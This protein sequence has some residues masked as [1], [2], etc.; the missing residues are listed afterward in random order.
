[1][2]LKL[3]LA[4]LSMTATLAL[5]TTA[6]ADAS[7][8]SGQ[9][10]PTEEAPAAT[11]REPEKEQKVWYGYQTL[12]ADGAALTLPIIGAA[13][14]GQS[15]SRA[16]LGTMSLISYAVTPAVIHM[17]HGHI[18][19]GFGD[20]ALRVVTPVATGIGGLFIG[21]AIGAGQADGK[22]P[23]T[24]T[25]TILVYEIYGGMVGLVTGVVAASAIDAGLLAWE[26]APAPKEKPVAKAK[27]FTVT[28][29]VGPT[30]DGFAAGVGGTF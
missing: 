20:L 3:S 30:K 4:A 9:S 29:S 15:S 13:S 26:T 16:A 12:I 19:K 21:A 8:W 10:A 24:G 5:T 22:D 2:S 28:P 23:L 25:V 27:P 1:M 7:P 11:V 6:S 14:D 18:G 17:A